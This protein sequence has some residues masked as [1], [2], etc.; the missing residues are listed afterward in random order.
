MYNTETAA[1]DCSGRFYCTY[2][3]FRTLGGGGIF[4]SPH[5]RASWRQISAAAGGTRGT[6]RPGCSS[7][8]LFFFPSP[9]YSPRIPMTPT[10]NQRLLNPKECALWTVQKALSSEEHSWKQ[11]M[12]T[13]IIFH[14]FE[15]VENVA[16]IAVQHLLRMGWEGLRRRGGQCQKNALLLRKQ[17]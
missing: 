16:Q 10:G 2:I 17:T 15:F 3:T 14:C 12:P 9:F 7:P 5:W 11:N 1:T 6:K 13:A 4:N 8:R